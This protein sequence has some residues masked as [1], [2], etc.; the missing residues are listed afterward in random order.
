MDCT[1]AMEKLSSY[2]DG[3]LIEGKEDLEGHLGT[4]L[5]CS[6]KLEELKA[7]QDMLLRYE[8]IK[9]SKGWFLRFRKQFDRLREQE[10]LGTQLIRLAEAVERLC[11]HIQKLEHASRKASHFGEIMTKDELAE[12]M[13]IS[14]EEVDEI[15][16]E[17]P[18]FVIAGQIR[19]R[20]KSVDMWIRMRELL[21]ISSMQGFSERGLRSYDYWP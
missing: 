4:C 21:P 17:L 7:I 13:K 6:L 11:D 18:R 20:K 2:I 19:F 3:E 5:S 14:V 1:E 8:G 12:Y 15:L 16:D 10:E 9:P